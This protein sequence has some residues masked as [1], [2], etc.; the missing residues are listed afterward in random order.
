MLVLDALTHNEDRNSENILVEPSDEP[1]SFSFWAIDM[2]AALVSRPREFASKRNRSPDPFA[3]PPGFSAA[4]LDRSVA[5]AVAR[6]K[7]F[8]DET[9]GA[10]VRAAVNAAGARDESVLFEAVRLRCRSA[11]EI[12]KDYLRRVAERAAHHAP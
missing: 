9:L 3:L 6:A 1:E 10:L 2:E 12:V 8:S 7:G 4:G 5:G 11:E